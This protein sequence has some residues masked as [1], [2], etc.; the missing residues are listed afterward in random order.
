MNSEQGSSWLGRR[1]R[2]EVERVAH[3]G[4]CVARAEGRVLFV[5]HAL[6]GELVTVEVTE[7][8][9]GSFCRADAIEVHAAHPGR[10][11]APCQYAGPGGCGGCD[12]QH[13]NPQTQREL[14]GA[15]VREQFERLAGLEVK[16]EVEAL[17]P[18]DLRWRT[19]MQYAVARDGSLGMRRHRSHDVQ[20]I[21][22]CLIATTDVAEPAL[23]AQ[24]WKPAVEVDVE[25]G[26]D[27]RRVVSEMTA[28]KK[29]SYAT[30]SSHTSTHRAAGRSWKVRGGGFWQ[31]HP[32]AADVLTAAAVSMAGPIPGDRVLD[33]Y[34]GMGLFAA[35]MGESVGPTGYVLGIE[36]SH[37]AVRDGVAQLGDLPQVELRQGQV[38]GDRIREAASVV[39]TED[40]GA[41]D[42]VVLDPPRKGAKREV[43]VAIAQLRPRAI[44]YVACDP[45]ALARDVASFAESGY[46]LRGLRAF[47][48]FPMTHHVEC[49][50][51]LA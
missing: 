27:H 36:G 38:T 50:A 35:A 7:D 11:T 45:A 30:G 21:D 16:V 32:Q 2:V 31:V 43:C 5:R 8:R 17:D 15:V 51:L 42:I 3:G 29:W 26:A 9:G 34:C 18:P 19:R 44:V 40:A 49:V 24:R 48:A 33:L 46:Q 20:P 10:V 14:K 25:A 37:T 13:A 28:N 41:Y 6:P 12:W 47:D 22:D 4:H 23:F 1:V 39:P